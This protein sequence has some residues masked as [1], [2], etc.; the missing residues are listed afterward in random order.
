MTQRF[1]VGGHP[2]SGTTFLQMLLDAHPTISCP[3]EQNLAYLIKHLRS[4][5]HDYHKVIKEMDRRTARQGVRFSEASFFS[6]TLHQAITMLM[7]AGAT[8][9]TTHTGINDNTLT[10]QG[11]LLARLMPQARFVFIVR[12][13]R[14]VAVSLW[15]HKLRTEPDYASREPPLEEAFDLVARTW[16]PYI[17]ELQEFMGTLPERCHLARYEDL[18]GNRRDRCLG[19]ILRFLEAPAEAAVLET[20]WQATD[21]KALRRREL[22]KSSGD[23]GFFRAGKADA[24]RDEAPPPALDRLMS[25]VGDE[26]ASVGYEPAS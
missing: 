13:P 25:A 2:K 6:A 1:F 14:A 3:S 9:Q 15:H 22:D 21:F 11:R 5:S 20:M 8:R 19:D 23:I 4:L 12:D 10:E 18:I 7:S 24:W 26:M 17:H 16:P